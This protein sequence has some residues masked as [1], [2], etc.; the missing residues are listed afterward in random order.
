M[1]AKIEYKNLSLAYSADC[2][3]SFLDISLPEMGQDKHFQFY[4]KDT[5]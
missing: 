3:I 1:F 5:A 4:F 2:Q